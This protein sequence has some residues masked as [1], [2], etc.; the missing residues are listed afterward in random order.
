MSIFK[1]AARWNVRAFKFVQEVIFMKHFDVYMLC[2][3]I[4]AIPY[5]FYKTIEAQKVYNLFWLLSGFLVQIGV[6]SWCQ[7]SRYL[8]KRKYCLEILTLKCTWYNLKKTTKARIV[9]ISRITWFWF[10]KVNIVIYINAS[11]KWDAM[12]LNFP[13]Y[14]HNNMTKYKFFDN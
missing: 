14:E 5:S 8:R 7:Y 11:Y 1:E 10:C 12:T 4:I 2:K 3:I 6:L 9:G 13:W